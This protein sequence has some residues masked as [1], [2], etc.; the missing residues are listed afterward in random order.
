MA[1]RNY[2]FAVGKYDLSGFRT[3]VGIPL[4]CNLSDGVCALKFIAGAGKDR[5]FVAYG[6]TD[7]VDFLSG[8][9]K[10]RGYME[11]EGDKVVPRGHIESA[12][13]LVLPDGR[14]FVEEGVVSGGKENRER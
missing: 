5:K 13:V 3:L 8:P 10:P 11:V 12:K 14:V 4:V 7:G 1:P 9:V 6:L 2:L